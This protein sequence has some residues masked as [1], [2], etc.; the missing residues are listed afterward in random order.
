MNWKKCWLLPFVYLLLV[1]DLSIQ[2]LAFQEKVNAKAPFALKPFPVRENEN[3]IDF[4]SNFVWGF[5][6]CE[7]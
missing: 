5:L 1:N 7:Y 3:A 6:A 2:D 4:D